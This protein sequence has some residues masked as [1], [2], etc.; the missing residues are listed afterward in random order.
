MSSFF[1][2]FSTA[3]RSEAHFR[4]CKSRAWW[5]LFRRRAF[6]CAAVVGLA[7]LAFGAH[8]GWGAAV[9]YIDDASSSS[10]AAQV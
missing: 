8:K 10:S 9:R 1:A 3:F 5:R 7:A 2:D 4:G 6:R